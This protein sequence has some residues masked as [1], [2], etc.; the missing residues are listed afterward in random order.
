MVSVMAMAVVVAAETAHGI[1]AG[2]RV[3]VADSE[4]LGEVWRGA[5]AAVAANGVRVAL[6]AMCGAR[7]GVFFAAVLPR[8]PLAWA[9]SQDA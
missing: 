5:L 2:W 9:G 3:A 4:G 1:A 6:R 8:M 7:P